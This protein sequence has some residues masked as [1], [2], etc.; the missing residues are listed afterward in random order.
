MSGW[1]RVD[2]GAWDR[3][4]SGFIVGFG[5]ALLAVAVMGAVRM[6]AG[7]NW[8]GVLAVGAVAAVLI[9]L[10]WRWNRVGVFVGDSGVRVRRVLATRTVAWASVKKFVDR[11]AGIDPARAIW[12]VTVD[13][14][15]IR[16]P[17][18]YVSHQV[19]GLVDRRKNTD[20]EP[21][22]MWLPG[23]EWRCKRALAELRT[24]LREATAR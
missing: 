1:R 13:G 17:L 12:V 7:S 4:G 19:Q 11:P 14:R 24:A 18:R 16:T 8:V 6:R 9:G 22:A 15:E 10:G 21:E 3:V 20:S 5:V 23:A 2:V